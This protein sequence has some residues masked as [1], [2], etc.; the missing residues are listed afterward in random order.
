MKRVS[1]GDRVV[2]IVFYVFLT[3]LIM[4]CAYPIWYCIVASISDGDYVNS[5]AFILLP[6]GIHFKG[7]TYAFEQKQLWVG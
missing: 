4:V 1:K 6:R 2:E 3:L 7:Y 5:G